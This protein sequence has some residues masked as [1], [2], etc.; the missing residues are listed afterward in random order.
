[1]IVLRRDQG[2]R[3]GLRS[4][5]SITN[6]LRGAMM[7]LAPQPVAECLSGHAQESTPEHPVRSNRPH[8]ALVPLPFVD[9]EHATG[10]VM[11]VAALLPR[12][13]TDEERALCWDVLGGVQQLRMG[14]DSWKVSVADAEEHRRALR[15]GTWTRESKVWSTVT[16]FVFDRYPKDPFSEEAEQVVRDAFV[17]AGFPEPSQLALH[18]NPWHLGVPKASVFPPAP[19][20]SG[21]PKRYHCHVRAMFAGKISGPVVVGA[22]RFY[23]YGLFLA[24]GNEGQ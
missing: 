18:Y 20:R 9:Y 19:A 22:G 11:G 16:P 6:A 13:L 8:V 3:A 14:W 24:M 5:L 7:S 1:M 21:K 15:P 4:T 23:G 17:R 10:D 12:N 2:K